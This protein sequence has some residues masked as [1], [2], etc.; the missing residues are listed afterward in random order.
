MKP[1]RKKLLIVDCHGDVLV[2]LERLFEDAGFDTTTAWTAQEALNQ[3]GSSRFDLVLLN[4][5]LPDARCEDLLHV[6]RKRANDTPC[7][8]MQSSGRETDARFE[9]LGAKGIICKRCFQQLV[10][11]VRKFLLCEQKQITAA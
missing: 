2:V 10:E 3:V 4:E 1:T 9:R 11:R 7:V 8:V 5:H 6:L